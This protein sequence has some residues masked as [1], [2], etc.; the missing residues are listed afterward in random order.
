[1]SC[2]G[3]LP[4]PVHS[5]RH[6]S[7]ARIRARLST[8]RNTVSVSGCRGEGCRAI[9]ER[10][11]HPTC[12]RHPLACLSVHAAMRLLMALDQF[13]GAAAAAGM[14]QWRARSIFRSLRVNASQYEEAVARIDEEVD[15]DSVALKCAVPGIE[16]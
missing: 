1:V 8:R 12:V 14:G 2:V 16:C 4:M 7:G 5:A 9:R 11:Q 10:Y 6:H 13:D 15:V 3:H